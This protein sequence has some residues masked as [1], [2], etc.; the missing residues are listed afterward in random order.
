M[1]C[2][3]L[4]P[5]GKSCQSTKSGTDKIPVYQQDGS[6]FLRGEQQEAKSGYDIRHWVLMAWG[7]FKQ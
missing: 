7:K 2:V 3:H 1:P 5:S 6:V 4:R